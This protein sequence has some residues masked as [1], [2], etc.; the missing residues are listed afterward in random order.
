MATF[1]I[2]LR[3]NWGKSNGKDGWEA[4]IH[5]GARHVGNQ[6]GTHKATTNAWKK[7]IRDYSGEGHTVEAKEFDGK[8]RL[9]GHRTYSPRG[10]EDHDLQERCPC[11]GVKGCARCNGTGRAHKLDKKMPA[12]LRPQ[13]GASTRSTPAS[14]PAPNGASKAPGSRSRAPRAQA[15]P[16]PGG[17]PSKGSK[18]KQAGEGKQQ[19]QPS[20]Y[21]LFVKRRMPALLSQGYD[22]KAAMAQIGAEWRNQNGR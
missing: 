9:I 21:N 8:G 10:A 1:Q 18:R 14:R 3:P 13:A 11:G 15:L 17:T 6:I 16:S 5:Q 20:K 2:T 12:S 4:D 19:R 7:A 22:N